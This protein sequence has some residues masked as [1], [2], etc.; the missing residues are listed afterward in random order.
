M[1]PAA[2]IWGEESIRSK[3]R[4]RREA[5][6]WGIIIALP[7]DHASSELLHFSGIGPIIVRTRTQVGL[8]LPLAMTGGGNRIDCREEKEKV[9]NVGWDDALPT[10][11]FNRLFFFPPLFSTTAASAWECDDIFHPSSPSSSR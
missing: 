10:D 7:S 11:Q 2:L 9:N 1:I 8:L 5:L 4:K 3:L 6:G